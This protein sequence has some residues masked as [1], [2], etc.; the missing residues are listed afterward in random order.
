MKSTILSITFVLVFIFYV[1]IISTAMLIEIGMLLYILIPAIREKIK[2]SNN[3]T[4]AK[5]EQLIIN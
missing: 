3:Y 4:S 1:V 5:N 2:S